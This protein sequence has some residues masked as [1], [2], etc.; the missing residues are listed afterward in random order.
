M[1]YAHYIER[2]SVALRIE[3]ISTN[4]IRCTLSNVDLGNRN[5]NLRELA[6]GSESAKALFQEMLTKASYELGFDT[7]DAPLMVEAIPLSNESIIIYVTKVDDP[8]ELDTRFAK[9]SPQPDDIATSFDIKI[10]NLLEG[11]FDLENKA[12]SDSKPTEN[13]KKSPYLRAYAFNTLDEV[14]EGAK[15]VGT[16]LGE[17]TLYKDNSKKRFILV[18]KNDTENKKDF[19]VAANILSEYGSKL[20]ATAVSESFYTEHF[21]TIIKDN[22]IA[23]LTNIG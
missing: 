16:Y 20:S 19:A 3:R 18:L 6:Y 17:S 2:G 7:E 4:R 11:A 9:F 15:A 22:A 13:H 12:D 23:L 21:K 10:N 8:E 14:I 1:P 5:L